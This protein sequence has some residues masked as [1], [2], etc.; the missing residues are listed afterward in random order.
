LAA[1][2]DPQS[3]RFL[4]ELSKAANKLYPPACAAKPV[5]PVEKRQELTALIQDFLDGMDFVGSGRYQDARS[6]YTRLFQQY[7][8]DLT[9][10]TNIAT[11]CIH[12]GDFPAA[13]EALAQAWRMSPKNWTVLLCMVDYFYAIGNFEQVEKCSFLLQDYGNL[14]PV[15]VAVLGLAQW[16][17]GKKNEA[18]KTAHLLLP[19]LTPELA[20]SHIW[21][22]ELLDVMKLHRLEPNDKE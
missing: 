20:A 21:F 1:L 5:E 22:Q 11:A 14:E 13:W 18:L 16:K 7:P 6:L 3:S 2:A 9:Q 12:M 17:M 15:G 19:Q 10:L 4:D 8:F